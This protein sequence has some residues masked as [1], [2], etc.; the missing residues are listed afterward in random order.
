[1]PGPCGGVSRVTIGASRLAPST[2]RLQTRGMTRIGWRPVTWLGLLVTAT[3]AVADGQ[4]A[5]GTNGGAVGAAAQASPQ[6]VAC[7]GR[8]VSRVTIRRSDRTVIDRSRAPGW[9][10]RLLQP[11]LNTEPTRESAVR[12]FLQLREGS[13]CTELRRAESERLLRLQPYLADAT[14][15]AVEEPDGRVAIEVETMDDLRQIVGIGVDGARPSSLE[16]GNGNIAGHGQLASVHW[17]DGGAYR[18]GVGM[19]YAHFHLLGAPNVARLGLERTP[20]GSVTSVSVGRPFLTDFQTVAMHAGATR[21]DGYDAFVRPSG[22]PVAL[23]V[24]LERSDLGAAWRLNNRGRFRVLVGGVVLREKRITGNDG[25]LV[26]DSGIVAA[27][28]S[29]LRG[30]YRTTERSRA[31]VVA[32]VRAL[33]FRKATGFDALEGTQDIGRGVQLST[34]LGSSIGG[35]ERGQ[36]ATANLF[37]GAGTARS[38]IGLRTQ[39][40]ALRTDG[41]WGDVVASGRLAWYSKPSSRQT[42]V[43]SAEFAGAWQ[44]GIPYQLRLDEVL[45]GLRGYNG[46]RVTGARRLLVRTERRVVLP[47]VSRHLGLGLAGFGEGA[48]MW[49]GS[50]PYGTTASRAS[51]G[52]SLLAAVP[53]ASRGL[54]RV[55]V[56]VPLVP[57]RG[58]RSWSVG[59]SYTITG[60]TFWREP[61]AVSRARV[62]EPTTEMFVWP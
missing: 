60:R 4:G 1:M 46:S 24:T 32:G 25:V 56:A 26:T 17:R 53:R 58:A 47:G 50:V 5:S 21:T 52:A 44:D 8:I 54:G 62:G 27:V 3:A 51:V 34:N 42:R 30:R 6:A 36:F 39:V 16:L 12:P 40:D 49:K 33:S 9:S 2:G 59:V 15:R 57:D 48:H 31:G 38:Y 55:D 20:L 14:V 37:L 18:D 22:D 13:R 28:D 43:W 45:T 10:R 61:S 29:T 41:S 7:D 35:V 23:A 19:R 11:L